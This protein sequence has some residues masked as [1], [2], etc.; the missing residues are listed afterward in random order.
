MAVPGIVVIRLSRSDAVG[1]LVASTLASEGRP[2]L[3]KLGVLSVSNEQADFRVGSSLASENRPQAD[4][5]QKPLF[6][7]PSEK[8][9]KCFSF[10]HEYARPAGRRHG[11]ILNQSVTMKTPAAFCRQIPD[12]AV[13]GVFPIALQWILVCISFAPAEKESLGVSSVMN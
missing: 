10:D 12:F 5:L 1:F 6:T 9:T 4:I 13:M 8:G 7:A 2:P 3:D 11:R